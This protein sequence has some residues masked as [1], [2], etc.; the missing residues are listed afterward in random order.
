LLAGSAVVQRRTVVER[1]VPP[2]FVV[3]NPRSGTKML[4]ELLN[5]SPDLWM[6]EVESHFIPRFTRTIGP[7]RGPADRAAFD[8][9]TA[10]LR[11]RARSGSG[12]IAAS[13]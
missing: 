6:S 10:A 12:S 3:G 8:R 9:L 1:A 2:F 4:R 7:L 5:A 11:G 13:T